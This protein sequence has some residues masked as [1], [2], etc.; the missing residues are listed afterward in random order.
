MLSL[1]HLY[2]RRRILNPQASG[3]AGRYCPDAR[4]TSRAL[5]FIKLSILFELQLHK[6]VPEERF[7][8]SRLAATGFESAMS[9]LPI[10]LAW[11]ER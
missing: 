6:L 5:E 10:I 4:P 9:T 8:L 2:E 3:R 1:L 11:C 7:A